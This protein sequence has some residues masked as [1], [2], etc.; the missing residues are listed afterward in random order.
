MG[1]FEISDSSTESFDP[2]VKDPNYE[3]DKDPVDQLSHS[4]DGN[5]SSLQSLENL[6]E[7]IYRNAVWTD[8]DPEL[9]VVAT[10]KNVQ[11][12]DPNSLERIGELD[13][14]A[15]LSVNYKRLMKTARE[16]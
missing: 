11:L 5:L 1:R 13:I 7:S 16:K 10:G 15:H 6:L 3:P 14:E 8:K 12:V 2:T 4:D 9:I